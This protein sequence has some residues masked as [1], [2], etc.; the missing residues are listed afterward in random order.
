MCIRGF[1]FIFPI[2][3]QSASPL[4]IWQRVLP[5]TVRAAIP[6]SCSLSAS[7][8]MIFEFS[9]QP[10]RVLTVTGNFTASTTD[11][12]ISTILSGKRII[13]LPAP[14]PAILFTGQPKFI[15]IISGPA[16]PA[17]LEASSAIFA[18][19]TIASGICPYI[20]IPI[21]FS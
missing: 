4:Y 11:L 20:C 2:K 15:S 19:S 13:P 10:R 8:T 6:T 9:S 16:P 5:C 18:A 7:S 1:S 17:I 3:L 14:L 21:G 12:V